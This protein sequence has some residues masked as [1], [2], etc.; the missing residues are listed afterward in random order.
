MTQPPAATGGEST[1]GVPPV[2]ALVG[3]LLIGGLLLFLTVRATDDDQPQRAAP[4]EPAEPLRLLP[5]LTQEEGPCSAT[6][7]DT[8]E[9]TQPRTCLTVDL[10]DGVTMERLQQI[11]LEM[12]E[13]TGT[14]HVIIEPVPDDARAFSDLTGRVSA[15]APPGNIVAMVVGDA[16]LTAVQV[17]EPIAPGPVQISGFATRDEAASVAEQLGYRD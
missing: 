11:S 6:G 15:S 4:A 7:P 3:L 17:A 2:A 1:R 16:V 13:S 12:S 14:W 5:V 8:F 9:T 10:A